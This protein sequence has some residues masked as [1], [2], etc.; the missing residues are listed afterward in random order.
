VTHAAPAA[1][2][3]RPGGLGL[4]LRGLEICRLPAGALAVDVGCGGG[5]A[6]AYLRGL[7]LAAFG[8]DRWASVAGVTRVPGLRADGQQLPFAAASLALMLAECSLSVMAAP[9]R[10]LAEIA[11][12]LAPGGWLIINDLYGY[13]RPL[14][15]ASG[16]SGWLALDLPACLR[17]L[18][19]RVE[20]WEDHTAALR[21]FAAEWFMAH[22][23]L[24]PWL[25][26]TG[27]ADLKNLGYFLA[28]ARRV[29]VGDDEWT[30]WN[31]CAN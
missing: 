14:V 21:A 5:Q 27:Q 18:G 22:G 10:A 4:T 20:L 17:G 1:G 23:T 29:A 2:L 15:S 31:A 16:G 9:L 13:R 7:G 6:A 26:C 8:V 11:R 19:F 3:L 24:E 12:V 25:G 28:V 30:T